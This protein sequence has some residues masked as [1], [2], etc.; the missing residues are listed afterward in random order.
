MRKPLGQ[1]TRGKTGPNR[2]RK[3]DT[4]LALAFPALVRHLPGLYVDLGYG[5]YPVT[6]GE[7]W[8]RLRAIDA[9]ARVLGVEID[10]ARVA[11]AQAHAAPGLE[12]RHG[13]FDLPLR[14]GERVAVIRA[15][16][17]LRQYDEAA[18]AGALAAL[19]ARLA[20]G[21]LLLEGTSDPHGRLVAFNILRKVGA[22]E[23]AGVVLAPR[24]GADFAPRALRAVLP[25]AFI[26]HAE[27]AGAIDRFFTAWEAAWQRARG[28]TRTPRQR[29]VAAAHA[30]AA[31]GGYGL[32]R[33]DALLRRGFLWLGADWPER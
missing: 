31:R 15:F 1:P 24:L 23:R 26:H 32:D 10:P 9:R 30:L 12:F 2:L 4:F 6:T 28:G 13:G 27:P 25:K 29:F 18:V 7:T 16:N 11:E 33:R 8:R 3:T 14:P 20:E 22:L 17:V 19:G 5:A 21:G